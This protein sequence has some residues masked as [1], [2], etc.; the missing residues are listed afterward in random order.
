VTARVGARAT[1]RAAVRGDASRAAC[2]FDQPKEIVDT[3]AV[4]GDDSECEA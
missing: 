2:R 3:R 1:V 4:R